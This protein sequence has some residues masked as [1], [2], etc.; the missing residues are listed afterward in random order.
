MQPLG[1]RS[2]PSAQWSVP[3]VPTQPLGLDTTPSPLKPTHRGLPSGRTQFS[4]VPGSEK[5]HSGPSVH[6]VCPRGESPSSPLSSEHRPR[7]LFLFPPFGWL[8]S[9]WSPGLSLCVPPPRGPCLCLGCLLLWSG[10][11]RGKKADSNRSAPNR[12]LPLGPGP[13]CAL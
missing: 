12:A 5:L 3:P 11:L 2:L 10:G 7:G 6:C 4:K 8:W 9:V 1:G 13:T